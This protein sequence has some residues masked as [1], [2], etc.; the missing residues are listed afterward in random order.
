MVNSNSSKGDRWKLW[1]ER[2]ERIQNIFRPA[3]F[4]ESNNFL[5]LINHELVMKIKYPR[6]VCINTSGTWGEEDDRYILL[7]DKSKIKIRHFYY[8]FLQFMALGK[9]LPSVHDYD[10]V[11]AFLAERAVLSYWKWLR[12]R[13]WDR[14]YLELDKSIPKASYHWWNRYVQPDYSLPD[15]RYLVWSKILPENFTEQEF[16]TVAVELTM[17]SMGLRRD[18]SDAGYWKLTPEGMEEAKRLGVLENI[19]GTEY[20]WQRYWEDTDEGELKQI[21]D[22]F[23]NHNYLVKTDVASGAGPAADVQAPAAGTNTQEAKSKGLNIAGKIGAS[24]WGE[25]E[26]KVGAY[27]IKARK[28]GAVDWYP[29]GRRYIRWETLKMNASQEIRYFRIFTGIAEGRGSMVKEGGRDYNSAV[30]DLNQKFRDAFGLTGIAF[31]TKGKITQTTLAS[32]RVESV[33]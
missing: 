20:L 33:L 6:K 8:E 7:D 19:E 15:C 29:K 22:T 31:T 12:D 24:C 25:I 9:L 1:V 32:F 26:V 11:T 2:E 5:H 21:L 18:K 13:A 23:G 4:N 17:F 3:P 30:H 28:V 16:L 14:R 10:D 27:G